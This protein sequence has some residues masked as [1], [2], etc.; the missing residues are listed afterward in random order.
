MEETSKAMLQNAGQG[1]VE[2]A[3]KSV[4]EVTMKL[5]PEGR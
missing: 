4:S 1:A 3:R 2:E 5:R